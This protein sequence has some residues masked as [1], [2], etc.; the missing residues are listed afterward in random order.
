MGFAFAAFHALIGKGR[1][2]TQTDGLCKFV[3]SL[4][5]VFGID[6]IVALE[7]AG[8]VHAFRAG[9]TIAA[10]GAA[11]LDIFLDQCTQGIDGFLFGILAVLAM[12]A[13][14]AVMALVTGTPPEALPL[15]ITTDIITYLFTALI[16]WIASRLDGVLEDQPHYV[17]RI[18]EEKN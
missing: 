18:A 10:S 5:F 15:Y 2:L 7:Q 12:Q 8:D 1:I 11:D 13:G 16:L 6:L 17:R 14:R 3:A 4:P 9:H